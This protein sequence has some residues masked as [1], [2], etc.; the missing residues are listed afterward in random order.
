MVIQRG[1]VHWAQLSVPRGSEPGFRRPVVVVS[2]NAFNRS[3]IN[4]VLAVVIT[5][6]TQLGAAPGN[7]FLSEVQS[8]LPKDSVINVSQVI[9]VDKSYIGEQVGSL[10]SAVVLQLEAGLR[11]VLG[12]SG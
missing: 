12:L 10:P 6:N 7:I 3:R 8:G 1:A 4:T 9:T 2:S 11:L 5:S